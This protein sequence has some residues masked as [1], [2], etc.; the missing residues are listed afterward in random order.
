MPNEIFP[1]T[2]GSITL[3]ASNIQTDNGRRQIVHELTSGN[4]H[5]VQDLGLRP[6]RVT[7]DLLFDEFPVESETPKTRFLILKTEVDAGT[8]AVYTHPVD[9]GFLAV[10]GDFTYNIDANSNYS[11]VRIEFIADEE[12]DIVQDA[13]VGTSSYAGAGDVEAAAS[14]HRLA[15]SDA[16]L[17]YFTSDGLT[18]ADLSSAVAQEWEAAT[19]V[20]TRAILIDTSNIG[21]EIATMI[22]SMALEDDLRL[23]NC[24]QSTIMLGAAVRNAAIAAT[25]ETPSVFPLRV[26]TSTSLLAL[27]ART[28]GGDQAEMRARQ[29]AEL[30]DVR[31]GGWLEPGEYLF[32]SKSASVARF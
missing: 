10:V 6:R 12:I 16:D 25:S 1:I 4:R 17:E 2:W 3:W 26:Q 31:F 20:A 27:C 29:V 8:K 18:I 32:P 24:Y 15:L 13:G 19:E 7:M 23:F 11:N 28:Y 14:A 22:T 21:N 5:P 30:N 9:G